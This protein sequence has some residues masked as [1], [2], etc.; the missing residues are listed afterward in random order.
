MEVARHV[1][2]LAERATER[3]RELERYRGLER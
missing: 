2:D 1:L 3:F